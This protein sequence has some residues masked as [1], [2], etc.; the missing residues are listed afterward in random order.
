M[1]TSKGQ[2]ALFNPMGLNLNPTYLGRCKG[3]TE[4]GKPCGNTAIF[5][6]GFCI[7]HGGATPPEYRKK[8]LERSQEKFAQQKSRLAKRID[9]LDRRTK[10]WLAHRSKVS[11]PTEAPVKALTAE[12]SPAAVSRHTSRKPDSRAAG[13][14]A[15]CPPAPRPAKASLWLTPISAAPK[16]LKAEPEP[17]RTS[18]SPPPAASPKAVEPKKASSDVQSQVEQGSAKTPETLKGEEVNANGTDPQGQGFA[19]A[20]A[21]K[22]LPPEHPATVPGLRWGQHYRATRRSAFKPEGL[23]KQSPDPHL[24]E[25]KTF[26]D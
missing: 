7:R 1:S 13:S 12:E 10:K 4:K 25:P 23:E 26:Q 22:S 14:T 18:Y 3:K 5:V 6:N 8:I 24:V 15:V 9:K 20:R 11:G 21:Y 19:N 17:T 16:P 2:K